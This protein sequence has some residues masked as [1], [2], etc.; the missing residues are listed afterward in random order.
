[1]ARIFKRGNCGKALD[2]TWLARDRM[3]VDG[4]SDE[5][6]AARHLV[7]L[8]V[9]NTYEGT[10]DLHA[11]ILARAINGIQAFSW[12]ATDGAALHRRWATSPPLRASP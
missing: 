3:G 10:Q 9:P 8:E 2:I 12:R 4:I 11:P 6:G 1:V 5:F 7:N